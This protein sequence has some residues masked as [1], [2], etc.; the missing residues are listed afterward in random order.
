MMMK[1]IVAH[2]PTPFTL[3]FTLLAFVIPYTTYKINQTIHKQIDP[4]WKMEEDQK[5]EN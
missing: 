2:L 1:I 5:S 4:P 3:F